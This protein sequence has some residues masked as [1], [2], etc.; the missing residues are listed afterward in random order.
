MK[1][2]QK[3]KSN[4]GFT[5]LETL[6]VIS[7]MSLALIPAYMAMINGYE[8]FHDES[9][10]QA[11]LSDVHLFYEE[12]NTQIRVSGFKNTQHIN[13]QS[14]LSKY[15]ELD[16]IYSETSINILRV[17]TVFYYFKNGAIVKFS[18]NYETILVESVA[19]FQ[20]SSPD[21]GEMI[22]DE[23]KTYR[24]DTTINVEGRQE[25]IFTS[26]YNRYRRGE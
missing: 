19:S 13:N 12:L 26:V 16:N 24:I 14:D 18:N 1:Q 21:V 4:S 17:D 10:Y 20:V 6:I 15:I 11:V 3:I 5:L 7:I 9:T 23:D 22:K 2:K 8:I 25:T